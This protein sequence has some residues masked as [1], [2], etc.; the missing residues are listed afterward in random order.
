MNV[1]FTPPAGPPQGA[2]PSR[3]IF[4][5][6]GEEN[7]FRMCRDFYARLEQSPIRAMFPED[8]A[9]ASEKL[10][11]FLVG[12]TGGP[13]LYHQ[14]HGEPRM[15]ARHLPFPIDE[16]AR[17]IWFESFR[18]TLQDAEQKYAFPPEHLPGFITFLDRFSAWMVNRAG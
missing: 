7:I 11:A 3:E 12:L 9:K 4:A 5:R 16:N 17:R 8:M 10:A 6:M 1:I 18:E 15:R 2:A 13:P 14:R